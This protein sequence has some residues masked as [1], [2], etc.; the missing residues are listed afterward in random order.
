MVTTHDTA[1]KVVLDDRVTS[2][3]LDAVL[4]RIETDAAFRSLLESDPGQALV[5]LDLDADHLRCI[6]AA[7]LGDDVVGFAQAPVV[8]ALFGPDA[9]AAPDATPDPPPAP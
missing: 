4:R 2:A 9:D 8:R 1:T 3:D 7:L 5:G 6:E